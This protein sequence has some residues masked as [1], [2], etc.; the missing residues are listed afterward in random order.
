[1]PPRNQPQPPEEN[2]AIQPD[3]GQPAEEV[4]GQ[5]PDQAAETA[6]EQNP[7][8][9]PEDQAAEGQEPVERTYEVTRE[10]GEVAGHSLGETYQA[11]YT[12]EQESALIE[13]GHIKRSEGEGQ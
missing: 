5:Q 9:V 2:P 8:L 12:P 11:T 13:G 10:R 1:M 3:P 6:P 7:A 4:P